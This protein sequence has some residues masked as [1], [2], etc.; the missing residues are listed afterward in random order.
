MRIE[1]GIREVE[2]KT[3]D[4]TKTRFQVRIKRK[5]FEANKLFD[6]LR[7]AR[8]FKHLTLS[9]DGRKAVTEFSKKEDLLKQWMEDYIKSPPLRN[10]IEK[11]RLQYLVRT[12]TPTKLTTTKAYEARLKTIKETFI[13]VTEQRTGLRALLPSGKGGKLIRFGDIKL[14]DLNEQVTTDYIRARLAKGIKKVTVRSEIAM[15]QSFCTKLRFTDIPAFQQLKG[16]P[17]ELADK[18]LLKDSGKKRRRRISEDEEERLFAALARCRNPEMIAIVGLAL[19]SGCRRGELLEL[20]WD[21]I[22]P[23]TIEIFDGKSGWREIPKSDLAEQVIA[24]IARKDERLFHYTSDGFSSN[25]DRV[26]KWANI[27][28]L[29]MHDTRREFISRCVERM[30]ANSLML[31]EATSLS[32]P[33]YI[34]TEY[35]DPVVEAAAAQAGINTESD[36]MRAVGHRD[37]RTT[38][39]YFSPKRIK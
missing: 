17:F 15:M 38:A 8:D 28:D 37:R 4:G 19:A 24:T 25:W 18:G 12:G 27:T 16:N 5:G 6:T 32:D 7:E 22:H 31:M 3:K 36:L 21:R 29:R 34:Q 2:W 30:Q 1:S 10:Y 33:T 14:A 35:I 9:D 39:L 20:T 11:Y 13:T 23:R 26:K